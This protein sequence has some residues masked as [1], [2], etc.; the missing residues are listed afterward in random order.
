MMLGRSPTGRAEALWR[1]SRATRESRRRKRFISAVVST[2]GYVGTPIAGLEIMRKVCRRLLVGLLSSVAWPLR[3]NAASRQH[4]WYPVTASNSADP[5]C[6]V[7]ATTVEL[8]ESFNRF[9]RAQ[10]PCRLFVIRKICRR[11]EAF[12]V[13][14]PTWRS[15]QGPIRLSRKCSP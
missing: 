13:S 9:L 5:F 4:V 2:E 11:Q 6:V 14:S 12:D 7:G 8:I 1:G 10:L 15:P 3:L